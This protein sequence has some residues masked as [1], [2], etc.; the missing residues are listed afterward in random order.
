MPYYVGYILAIAAS[1]GGV[2]FFAGSEIAFVSTNRFQ[3]RSMAKRHVAG[4]A[5][6]K[7]LLDN[8]ATLLSVTLVGTNLFV[9]LASA[10]A[11]A[12]LSMSLGSYAVVVST[13]GITA[14]IL[15]FGE[16][17]PKAIAR[18]N[19]EIFLAR[20]ALALGVAYYVLYPIARVTA[21]IGL[22]VARLTSGS[23]ET[24]EVSR[25]E[26][27]ALVKEAAQAGSGVPPRAY[28]HRVLDLSRMKVT[29]VMLPMDEVVCI[30]EESTVNEALLIASKSGHS[31]Y[32]VYKRMPE[33]VVG[34]LHLK[35]LLGVP[36]ESK[37][38]VF[39]RSAYF[40]PETQTL[41]A[42]LHQMRE[43]PRH[44]GI[45]TDEYGRPIGILTFEDLVEEIVG[46]ISDEYDRGEPPRIEL[47][48]VISGSTPISV[49]NDELGTNIPEGVYDTVAGFI[50]DRAGT[51][52]ER[53]ESI[54]FDGY[55]FQVIKVK[56]KRISKVK[57]TR[58][59]M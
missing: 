37:V 49:L 16:I 18:T 2:A 8:P 34:V 28:A 26:I 19:P 4:A 3:V 51:V 14:L 29:A 1:I 48:K 5:I 47:G 33:N 17:I 36:V 46:D 9:V 23:Q 54:T 22:F 13:F 7:R 35:D 57:V 27:K 45:V 44:L 55:V 52:C 15:L 50:M 41:S 42:A 20:C 21:S 11:T 40:V 30:D 31:R 56:G 6:A 58:Q 53:G 10:L 43:E 32:P 39:A 12:L 38:N 24:A 59:G 25:D